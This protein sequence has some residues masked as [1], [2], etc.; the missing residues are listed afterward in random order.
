MRRT[1]SLWC[2]STLAVIFL[3]WG[4]VPVLAQEPDL[5]VLNKAAM[6]IRAKNPRVDEAL[7]ARDQVVIKAAFPAIN[8]ALAAKGFDDADVN[9]AVVT[10]WKDFRVPPVGLTHFDDQT[11]KSYVTKLGR[12][13][14]QSKPT[15]AAIDINTSRQEEKTNTIKWLAPGTYLFLLSKDGYYPEEEKRNVAEGN[16]PPLS[17]TLRERPK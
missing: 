7:L 5:R 14:I 12:L 16:N 15:E 10:G 17:K 2:I 13:G 6:E 8:A 3:A 4:N 11:F 9:S 1:H